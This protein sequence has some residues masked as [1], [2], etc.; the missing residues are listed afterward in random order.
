MFFLHSHAFTNESTVERLPK[1]VAIVVIRTLHFFTY[2]S[3]PIAYCEK[4]DYRVINNNDNLV[5]QYLKQEE[6]I[7]EKVLNKRS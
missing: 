4:I 2:F 7:C 1:G 3:K 5:I 6:V